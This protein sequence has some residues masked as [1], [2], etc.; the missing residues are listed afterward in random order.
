MKKPDLS[1][2]KWDPKLECLL[3][4]G[5]LLEESLFNYTV[6]TYK[7]PALNTRLLC[8][9][10]L[11]II[12]K[13]ESGVIREGALKPIVEELTDSLQ[14][15]SI[16]ISLIG[17]IKDELISCL[18][19]NSS[20]LP[21]TRTKIKLLINSLDNQYLDKIKILLKH[22]ITENK[23]KELITALTRTFVTDLISLGHSPD[24]I[25]WQVVDFFFDKNNEPFL[26]EDV[27]IIEKFLSMF[28][29][30]E[31][32]WIL[33]FRASENFQKLKQFSEQEGI[34]VQVNS[35]VPDIPIKKTPKIVKFLSTNLSSPSYLK[36]TNVKA[37][38]PFAARETGE[39]TIEVLE[40]FAR[41]HVHRIEFKWSE[42]ALVYS[43]DSTQFGIYKKPI[44][45]TMKRPDQDVKDLSK[46]ME[47]T[48]STIA[49]EK[50]ERESLSRFIRATSRHNIATKSQLAESQL[51][52]FWAA[53]EVLFSTYEGGGDKVIQIAKS[54]L[55]FLS[56]EYAAKLGGYLLSSLRLERNPDI[57]KV[58]AEVSEGINDFERCLALV[59]IPENEDKR[60]KI[61][62]YLGN[63]VLLK[64]RIY[65]LKEQLCSAE[66]IRHL[67]ESHN[68]RVMWQ[69]QRIYRTR[70]EIIH[71]GQTEPFINILVENIHTYLDRIFEVMVETAN[72]TE[73]ITSIDEICLRLKLEHGRH[74]NLL[75]NAKDTAC[76][77]T[78]YKTLL[79]GN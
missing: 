31:T 12:D 38:D 42:E 60:N 40:D 58:L 63:N 76:D 36:L 4:F 46:L 59:A 77:K 7:S 55:P 10:S 53:I 11:Q 71:S 30:P 61:Y 20:S 15:D 52:E 73:R 78:N 79:F 3:L 75:M 35:M 19:S 39:N 26:I 47:E 8:H 74:L 16:A 29:T 13:I 56:I 43:A 14:K 5:Q 22:T 1:K 25:Y 28:P 23:K 45:A 69:I 41:F 57:F 33:L 17:N 62:S 49:G 44:P 54:I 2:W 51:L 37:R 21:E 67:I 70:N 65:V 32:D 6:D 66:R 72:K 18:N 50:F 64:N 24:Y 48:V 34:D 68:N 27:S 9:E